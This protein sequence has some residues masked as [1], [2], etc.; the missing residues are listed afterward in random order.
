MNGAINTL[1]CTSGKGNWHCLREGKGCKI[2]TEGHEFSAGKKKDTTRRKKGIQNSALGP[3]ERRG[4]AASFFAGG[5]GD[6]PYCIQ[7]GGDG[8]K[9]SIYVNFKGRGA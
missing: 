3:R 4:M 8:V 9:K 7:T 5:E 1:A 6:L 2:G